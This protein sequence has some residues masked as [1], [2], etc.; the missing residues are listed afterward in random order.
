MEDSV[1]EW[2]RACNGLD[3]MLHYTAFAEI[4]FPCIL[5]HAGKKK[6]FGRMKECSDSPKY[7]TE[8]KIRLLPGQSLGYAW[9][10]PGQSLG[11]AWVLPG[12]SLGYGVWVMGVPHSTWI[13][14][15]HD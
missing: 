1:N 5:M 11:Y 2:F 9:V 8:G 6:P 3:F 14:D 7:K 15:S 13:L 12:Q 4:Y 10:L